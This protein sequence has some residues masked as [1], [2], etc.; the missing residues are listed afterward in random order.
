MA[1][2]GQDPSHG[3]DG[4]WAPRL[5]QAAIKQSAKATA[6]SGGSPMGESSSKLLTRWLK[7]SLGK[8]LG[9]SLAPCQVGLAI[10][11]LTAWQPALVQADKQDT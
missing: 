7:D 4:C 5:S 2:V 9:S 8:G 6:S 1:F 3:L 11:Q 10:G